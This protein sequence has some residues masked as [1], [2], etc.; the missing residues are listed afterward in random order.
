[1]SK[2]NLIKQS[3]KN[4][5]HYLS[6]FYFLTRNNPSINNETLQF[7][8]RFGDFYLDINGNVFNCMI[9]ENH[10]I[11]LRIYD[12]LKFDTRDNKYSFFSMISSVGIDGNILRNDIYP[13]FDINFPVVK[14]VHLIQDLNEIYN[15]DIV[16]ELRNINEENPFDDTE[17]YVPIINEDLLPCII[18]WTLFDKYNISGKLTY[19]K[20]DIVRE[21]KQVIDP[22]KSITME[23][24]HKKYIEFYVIPEKSNYSHD[25]SFTQDLKETKLKNEKILRDF[26]FHKSHPYMIHKLCHQYSKKILMTNEPDQFIV[27]NTLEQEN[28]ELGRR[29]ELIVYWFLQKYIEGD[30]WSIDGFSSYNVP[31]CLIGWNNQIRESFKPFDFSI[32]LNDIEYEIEVKS[33]RGNEDNVFYLSI[34]EIEELLLDPEHYFLLRLSF[35]KKGV[36]VYGI[37]FNEEFYGSF[38]KMKHETIK[39]V[40]EKLIEWKEYYKSKTIRFTL[41]Q[42]EIVPDIYDKNLKP[43]L[44]REPTVYDSCYWTDFKYFVKTTYFSSSDDIDRILDSYSKFPEVSLLRKEYKNLK[45]NKKFQS[46]VND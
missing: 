25:R 5:I 4:L 24:I 13:L 34:K 42:F 22:L 2:P 1:M 11:N 23:E 44:L 15:T 3:G 35:L 45:S 43:D 18:S 19:H 10:H 27:H 12:E 14:E 46:P 31:E 16:L 30:K 21:I 29:T 37:Q 36:K 38:F 17:E 41:D 6:Y 9:D 32:K 40:K 7:Y 33:T 39:I 8:T 28:E 20:E 26:I